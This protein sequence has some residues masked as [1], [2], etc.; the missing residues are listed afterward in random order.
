M[1]VFPADDIVFLENHPHVVADDPEYIRSLDLNGSASRLFEGLPADWINSSIMAILDDVV[2]RHP[3]RIAV[4]DNDTSVSYRDLRSAIDRLGEAISQV[5]VRHGAVGILLPN[6]L[7]HPAAVL[8]CSAAGRLFVPFDVLHPASRIRDLAQSA[9][10][11]AMIVA[12]GSAE[13][14]SLLPPDLMRIDASRCFDGP[15]PALPARHS[16]GGDGPAGVLHTSGSSGRPKAVVISQ[17]SLLQRVLQQVNACH[18]VPSDV[19]CPLS[20]PGT[21]SGMREQLAAL[22][23][24]A[25]LSIVDP[26]RSSLAE[27][28]R[29]FRA[30]QVS[31]IWAVPALLRAILQTDGP[32]EDFATLRVVRIGGDMVPWRDVTLLRQVLPRPCCIQISFGST[33]TPCLQWFVPRDFPAYGAVV[34]L[35]YQL[36]GIE[37]AVLDESGAQVTH[38][39]T[40]EM[41]VSSRFV[42]LG[43]WQGGACVQ[44]PFRPRPDAPS[45]RVYATGDLVELRPDGLYVSAGRKDR[46]VKIRGQR[47][48]TTEIEAALHGIAGVSDAAVIAAPDD[49]ETSLA[50]FVQA[51]PGWQADALRAEI[52]LLLRDLPDVM[53]PSR[54]HVVAA[55]PRLPSAKLDLARLRELDRI[56]RAVPPADRHASVSE[57]GTVRQI[58]S[59]A[60]HDALAPNE[61]GGGLTWA[62]SGGDSLR[63]LEFAAH[64]ERDIRRHV[65]LELLDPD[66][67]LDEVT[68]AIG[69][70]LRPGPDVEAEDV[71][72]LVFFFPGIED[73]TVAQARFRQSLREH[74][75]F[76]AVRYPDW[77]TM[78]G[79]GGGLD[80][81][82]D[83]AC[84]QI[85]A[86]PRH[87]PI[88]LAGYSFG[89]AV[90]LVLASR[91]AAQ[92]RPV[93]W[94]AVFDLDLE[95]FTKAPARF[96]EAF[97][98][99]VRRAKRT[100]AHGR[101]LGPARSL[102]RAVA[103]AGIRS[104]LRRAATRE[105]FGPLPFRL[106]SPGHLPRRADV[107]IRWA[108]RQDMAAAWFRGRSSIIGGVPIVLFRTDDHPDDAPPDIGW[109]AAG[110]NVSVHWSGGGHLTMLWP[111]HGATL[112]EQFRQACLN[113]DELTAA[114]SFEGV[115]T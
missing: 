105:A 91:L 14:A 95:Q 93:A 29:T 67:R 94:L 19:I 18:I 3:D 101:E 73:D 81:V 65:P 79:Q 66:M 80:R 86:L 60:W 87:V 102:I 61:G 52:G 2:E 16:L 113:T 68:A 78:I 111:P 28:R 39:R 4:R 49:G 90:A 54:L 110:K 36:S 38:G 109:S 107:R 71:R 30:R 10:L 53:R 72:P 70:L 23:T 42:A 31:V 82:V 9:A 15:I 84:A 5:P 47:V 13:A 34:P 57:G 41:V 88:R 99:L 115:N 8:A 17:A 74:V 51:R 40:G 64:V 46:Q 98:A 92:H 106:P 44:G 24:G 55:I 43:Y 69:R 33:E 108:M 6:S 77:Q 35:G 1:D 114:I 89:A 22:L 21:I 63:L 27:M 103:Q 7:L 112:A 12:A 85:L 45:V 37:V 11:D 26:R 62:D 58:V 83:L 76:D 97:P 96:S 100:G 59:R 104:L 75:R 56:R 48:D 25:T 20:S 50:A 32:A